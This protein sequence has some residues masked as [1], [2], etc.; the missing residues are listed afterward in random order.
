MPGAAQAI[1]TG[2]VHH[3]AINAIHHGF[4][5]EVVGDCN[6]QYDLLRR[7]KI[8]VE[9]NVEVLFY[10][11]SVRVKKRERVKPH[12]INIRSK[13]ALKPV[14]DRAALNLHDTTRWP[15]GHGL[16]VK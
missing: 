12:A 9:V 6:K 11:P 7:R 3:G 4:K 10:A 2:A 13:F 14:A 5:S 15:N 8:W 16:P 1:L